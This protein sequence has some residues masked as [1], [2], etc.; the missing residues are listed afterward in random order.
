MI[1]YY[2]SFSFLGGIMEALNAIVSEINGCLI[3][4]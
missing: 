2:L 3:F 1:D 4:H